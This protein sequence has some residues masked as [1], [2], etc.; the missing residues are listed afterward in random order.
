[1]LDRRHVLKGGAAALLALASGGA[2]AAVGSEP[3]LIVVILRGAMDGLA[4]VAPYGDPDYAT[5]R[6]RLAL[7]EPGR[8]GGLLDLG[9]MFGLHPAMAALHPLYAQG[10]LLPIHATASPYRGRSHFDAQMVLENGL[11]AP[12]STNDGWMNRTLAAVP[13]RAGRRLSEYRIGL[14]VGQATPLAMRGAIPISTWAPAAPPTVSGDLMQRLTELYAP[15]PTFAAALKQGVEAHAMAESVLGADQ[16]MKSAPA[17][18]GFQPQNFK[19]LAQATGKL[20]AATDGP[21]VAVLEMGGW[22]THSGQGALDGRL[23][24]LLG[25]LANGLAA[26]PEAMGAAWSNT[27]VIAMTEFGRTVAVNGTGGTD[28]GTGGC[29]LLI[30]GAVR[31]GR[32]LADWPGLSSDRLLDGRDLRPT[33]DLRG[34]VKGVLR[35]HLKIADRNLDGSIFPDSA[36]VKPLSGLVRA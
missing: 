24:P 16:S 11:N 8:E 28:H 20:L 7:N 21:R 12:R 17:R 6:G 1:M 33:I 36:A 2:Q 3:R 29:A 23:A 35:D 22:D 19:L 18:R 27:V 31:G 15:D 34:V 32:V 30:G 26:L 5:L 25:G 9:G 4:A 10:A 14:S 13:A